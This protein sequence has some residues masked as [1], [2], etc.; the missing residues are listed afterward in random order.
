[1]LCNVHNVTG[2]KFMLLNVE[3]DTLIEYIYENIYISR[4]HQAYPIV[5][6]NSSTIT[7]FQYFITFE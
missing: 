4:I 5:I 6:L 3:S 2:S 7:H 1:M